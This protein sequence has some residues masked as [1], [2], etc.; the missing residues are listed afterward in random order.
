MTESQRGAPPSL[1]PALRREA[2]APAR[3]RAPGWLRWCC[4]VLYLGALYAFLPFAR[5]VSVA[6]DQRHAL[7]LV[8]TL[9]FLVSLGSLVFYVVF[10]VRLSDLAAFTAIAFLVGVTGA[11][12]LG[13]SIPEERVHFLQFGFL[14][15]LA[16]W[17]FAA[18]LPP[19]R[20]YLAAGVFA[21]SA[22]WG[23][24]VIQ[25]FLPDRVY[26]LRDVALNA[27]A[28][29]LAVAFDEAVHNR[30][31]WA[32]RADDDAQDPADRG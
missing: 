16:R 3:W 7:G 20:Q 28:V 32:S 30:L 4:V 18:R 11:M 14:T 13:L 2:T 23:D 6:L 12:V 17:A 15:V 10:G 27:V 1:A 8:I 26:D 31:R 9:L 25:H 29:V 22:G 21:A 5:D 19:A 24:E